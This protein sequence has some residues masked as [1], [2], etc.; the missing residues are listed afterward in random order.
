MGTLQATPSLKLQGSEAALQ[1][2]CGAKL[3]R[4]KA[5]FGHQRYCTLYPSLGRSRCKFHGGKTPQGFASPHYRHGLYTDAMIARKSVEAFLVARQDANLLSLTDEI[6]VVRL[7]AADALRKNDTAAFNE[8]VDRLAR[9]TVREDN[10][11]HRLGDSDL[12]ARALLIV[13]RVLESLARHADRGTLS[14]VHDE[15]TRFLGPSRVMTII[16]AEQ[17]GAHA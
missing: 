16:E 1:G 12:Q 7:N 8:N 13:R 2:R 17:G 15:V 3:A 5:R 10:R 6:A 14:K 9:L 4:S 11:R